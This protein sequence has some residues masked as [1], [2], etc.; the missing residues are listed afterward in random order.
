MPTRL[1]KRP[2]TLVSLLALTIGCL[3]AGANAL[4]AQ[5][6]T[7]GGLTA[8]IVDERGAVLPDVTVTVERDGSPVRTVTTNREGVATFGVLAPGSYSVLAEEFGY[9]PVRMRGV[10]VFAASVSRIVIKLVHRPPPITTVDEQPS[11]ATVT[12]S[13][14]T[15]SA[16]GDDLTSFARRT[17]ITG[18][19]AWFAEPDVPLDGRAGFVASANG[20]RPGYSSLIVD[21]VRE[22][23][24]RHPGLPSEPASAPLFG[25]DGVDQVSYIGF[26]T[27]TGLAGTLGGILGADTRRGTNRFSIRS[28]LG[29]SGSKL[30]GRSVDNPGDSSA[31]S[32]QGGV[33]MG[34]PIKGDTASW[35]LR[36]DYQQLEQPS[37]NPFEPSLGLADTNANLAGAVH[38]AAQTLGSKD[39][40]PWLVP[41][42][43]TWKGGSASGR[44][45]WRFGTSTLLAIRAG[46]ASWTETN[47]QV[48][49]EAINGSGVKLSAHDISGAATLTTGNDS[50]SSV[51][52]LGVR[53]S[54]RD[55]TGASLPLTTLVG[56]AIALGGA[57]TLPGTFKETGSDLSEMAMFRVGSHT[58]AVGGSLQHRS[59]NYDWV[60]GSA[61]TFAFGDLATFGA[62]QGSFYQAIASKPAP[63][64]GV[65]DLAF[66]L[67]DR[68]QATSVVQLFGG[69]RFEHETLPTDAITL[70]SAWARVSGV[71]NNITPAGTKGRDFGPRAGF[72]WDVSGD[73]TTM[74]AGNI[75]VLPGQ[76]DL[77]ALA[78]AAQFDGGVTVRRATGTLTWPNVGPNAGSSAGQSLTLFGA[79]VRQPRAFKSDLSISQRLGAATTMTV[80]GAYRH[81]DYLLQRQDLNRVAA[82]VATGSD[83]RPI[84]GTLD[85]FGAMVTPAVGS[86][87]RFSEFDMV[88]AFASSGYNDYYEGSFTL[89]QRLGREFSGR[90]SYAYSRTTDNLPGELSANPADHLSPFPDGLNG[91]RWEVGRSDLD[92]PHRVAATITYGSLATSPFAAGARLRYRSGLPFTPG[93]RPGVDVNGDGSG[94]ND[95]AAIAS[96]IPGMTALLSANACLTPASGTIATRNSCREPGVTTVD[97]FASLTLSH[98]WSL[99]V[100]AFNVVGT[101]TG[102]YDHAALLIDPKG[103]ITTDAS[104]HTVLPLIAN[105]SFGQLLSRRGD[106]RV[107][108]VGIRVEN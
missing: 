6:L 62:G 84:Y 35:F 44:L 88:Y 95:P 64:L 82:P 41:T 102:L 27:S 20:L 21:G 34:G 86:N 81:A 12:G 77:A 23:L 18:V 43:R 71:L 66:Q 52:R 65:N 32:V 94:A 11:N 83:G 31:S 46:G 107:L 40:T 103:T 25:R 96:T 98:R 61:G 3:G 90:L 55:W 105:P 38:A 15:S 78:E 2:S 104:G 97:L 47:P 8:M 42:V 59:V 39:V 5:G 75:G 1:L 100:D 29:Y 69:V 87:R 16:S 36:A 54:N 72:S 26:G 22:T 60:P 9:Q 91:T 14:A 51:T 53:T 99:T 4:S 37:A 48:G 57:A 19:A 56:D 63:D 10:A 76:Y 74:V 106:P 101:A 79:D 80:A 45:D 108:R 50:W 33:A 7:I 13:P 49:I 28:W 85:Q 68:W 17:D 92:I 73:G 30:G 89:E 70:S 93:F 24:L 58:I 67:E